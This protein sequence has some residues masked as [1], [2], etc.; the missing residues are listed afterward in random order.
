MRRATDHDAPVVAAL[1]GQLGY[2]ASEAQ[3]RVRLRR[4]AS[5]PGI[6]VFVAERDGRVIGLA[7][8]HVLTVINRDEG[9][10]QLTALVV[11][12][13][14]KRSGAGRALVAAVV[15]YARAAGCGRLSVTTHLD[16][17]EA[18]AFYASTGFELTGRRYGM[19]LQG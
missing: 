10:A 6:A 1:L 16:R 12:A 3:A 13:E 19:S 14:N 17:P 4:L 15:G 9:L 11:D 7:T 18:H 2:A 8:A 5:E